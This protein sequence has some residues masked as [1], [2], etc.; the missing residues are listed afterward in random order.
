MPTT[1]DSG[2][3]R[4][5]RKGHAG[6]QRRSSLCTLLALV[7]AAG[8]LTVVPAGPASACSCRAVSS[9]DD[10]LAT[11]DGGFIGTLIAKDPE[12][13]P[14]PGGVAVPAGPPVLHHFAVE[15]VLKGDIASTVSVRAS[16]DGASCGLE[17][18]SGQRLGLL[19]YGGP[20]REWS[21]VLCGQFGVPSLRDMADRQSD[22]KWVPVVVAVTLLLVLVALAVRAH[23]R[24][25]S[26]RSKK[27]LLSPR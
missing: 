2:L 21:A 6:R 4:P 11:A 14:P 23:A 26:E 5:V 19:L 18:A 10:Q 15:R 8:A 22:R 1:P 12:P 7:V 16:T 27:D 25:H 20:P 3:G 13:P 17:V 24:R 9:A